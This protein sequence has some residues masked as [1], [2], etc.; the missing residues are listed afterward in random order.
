MNF[1]PLRWAQKTFVHPTR[2]QFENGY[3]RPDAR[4]QLDRKLLDR[5]NTGEFRPTA[6]YHATLVLHG[7]NQDHEGAAIATAFM[8]LARAKHLH[9]LSPKG[10]TLYVVYSGRPLIGLIATEEPLDRD[11]AMA[12]FPPG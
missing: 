5:L 3:H 1:D 11:G 2:V 6:P 7:V 4:V 9:F 8:M 10:V 12:H